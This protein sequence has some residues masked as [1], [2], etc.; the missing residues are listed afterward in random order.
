MILCTTC[1]HDH[2]V[3]CNKAGTQHYP[4]EQWTEEEIRAEI[5]M[6]EEQI[7]AVGPEAA[8]GHVERIERIQKATKL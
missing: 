3:W 1:E 5:K 4:P 2:C 7:A 8:R 6:H